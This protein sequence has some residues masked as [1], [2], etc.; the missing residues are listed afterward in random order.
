M[1][2]LPED[3]YDAIRYTLDPGLDEAAVPTEII[4]SL[5][6]LG[7]AERWALDAD[8]LALTRTGDEQESLYAAIIYRTAGLLSPVVPQARQINMAGHN[9]TL[10]YAETAAERTSRLLGLADQM[11][12]T[13]LVVENVLTI[14]APLFV[15][16]AQGRRA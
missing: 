4:A 10:N 14:N 3:R 1:A 6:Y 12:H 15:T 7:A 5:A 9:V 11:L 13:Y 2:I 16:T 8:P